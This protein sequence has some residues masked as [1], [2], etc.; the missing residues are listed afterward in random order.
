[1][2]LRVLIEID[3]D[4]LCGAL[5][6]HSR[7][8]LPTVPAS[9]PNNCIPQAMPATCSRH[10]PIH[11]RHDDIRHEGAGWFRRSQQESRPCDHDASAHPSR[12]VSRRDPQSIQ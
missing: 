12:S 8:L 10:Q 2:V 6:E 3:R 11:A 7:L 4:F 9:A 1:M 5:R